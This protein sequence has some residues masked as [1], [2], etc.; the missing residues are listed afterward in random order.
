MQA[1]ME[2][3]Y[4]Q[5]AASDKSVKIPGIPRGT[6][7]QNLAGVEHDTVSLREIVEKASD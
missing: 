7:A 5:Q 1:E 3:L 2:T 4:R 6:K